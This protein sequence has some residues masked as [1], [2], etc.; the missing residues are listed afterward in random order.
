MNIKVKTIPWI[1]PNFVRIIRPPRSRHEGPNFNDNEGFSL[2]EVDV[3][4]LSEM[5]DEFRKEIF[6]KAK[7][8]DPKKCL[9]IDDR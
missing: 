6:K 7:K 2:D 9:E 1:T 8:E 3:E 5:C 4:T